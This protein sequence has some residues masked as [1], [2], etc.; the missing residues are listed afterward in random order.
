MATATTIG[1]VKAPALVTPGPVAPPAPPTRATRQRRSARQRREAWVALLFLSPW[2]VGF[3]LFTAGPILASLVLSFCKWDII[4]PAKWIGL[5]NYRQM[6]RD[7]LLAKSLWNTVVYAALYI[8][9]ANIVALGMAML[10]NQK[11]PGMR[12]FRTLFYLPT[13]TQGVATY[14][15]WAVVFEPETGV[16]NRIL[17]LFV[18]HPPAWLQDPR[19]SKPALV[20]VAVWGVGGMML[21]YLAGLTNIPGQ[22]YE[23]AE[24]DGAGRVRKFWNVTV[25]MLSP[26][27]LFNVIMGTI[28]S[29]QVFTAA[30]ILT[31]GGPSNSTL[32]YVYYLFNRAFV[33]FNMGYASAMAW[34]LFL[35][36]LILTLVQMG[37]S[38]KWVHYG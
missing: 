10:L 5:A 1:E 12:V 4:T 23:A 33:F 15:L 28:A 14:V 2:I 18:S 17:R 36:V 19:W 16:F 38:R 26:T 27:I 7:P 34:L 35:I 32:F 21:V 22:L 3:L 20:I 24:I 25:P 30:L 11:L 8:P 29:F 31:G 37:L 9:A 6:A 13:L